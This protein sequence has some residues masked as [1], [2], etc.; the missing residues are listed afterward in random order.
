[1]R[2]KAP[3][4]RIA[5]EHKYLY[6]GGSKFSPEK[7]QKLINLEKIMTFR[8]FLQHSPPKTRALLSNS[9]F[10]QLLTVFKYK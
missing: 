9:T 5:L 4:F 8:D 7:D 3:F 2:F 1:M 6:T 10:H